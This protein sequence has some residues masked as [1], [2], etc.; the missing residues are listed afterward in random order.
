MTELDVL[1]EELR[2]LSKRIDEIENELAKTPKA[3]EIDDPIFLLS[4]EEYEKYKGVIVPRLEC[5]WWLRS[6]GISN[7][8]AYVGSSGIIYN[9]GNDIN[10]IYGAVRPVILYDNNVIHNAS[11]GTSFVFNGMTWVVIDDKRCW[12]IAEVPI[13]FRE[14]DV[15]SNDYMNSD[16]RQYLLDWYEHHTIGER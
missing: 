14:F 7:N 12:A 11:V 5:W 2:S 1:R 8:A 16:I 3:D 4:I 15:E 6:P 10:S 9:D 13:T